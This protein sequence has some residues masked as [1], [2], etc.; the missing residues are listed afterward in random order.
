M[1]TLLLA[2]L[3]FPPAGIVLLWLRTRVWGKMAGS[4][5]IACWSVA[6][7]MLFFGLR[8]HVDGS[9]I[10]PV[11]TFV[12]RESHEAELERSRARQI[13]AA[14]VEAAAPTPNKIEEKPLGVY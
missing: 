13:T 14:A 5:L 6:W 2:A 10:R 9:G 8:F 1:L 4:A 3:V 12:N 11:P 7:L